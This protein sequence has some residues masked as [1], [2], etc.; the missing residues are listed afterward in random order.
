LRFLDFLAQ[1]T[2][3]T[4]VEGISITMP[5]PANFALHKLIILQRKREPE[6]VLKDKESVIKI[7]KALIEKAE[8]DFIRN[9]FSS[10]PQ[11]WQKKVEKGIEK[12]AEK[13]ILDIFNQIL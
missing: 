4:K 8:Q 11:K 13:E 1:N 5:H 12:F 2:I 9:I 10:M 6:K 3:Q 7:L